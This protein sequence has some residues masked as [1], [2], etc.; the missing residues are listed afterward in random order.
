MLSDHYLVHSSDLYNAWH[1]VKPSLI[2][3][4]TQY[5]FVH[6]VLNEFILRGDTEILAPDLKTVI[7]R[8]NEISDGE[9]GF[10]K[11]FTVSMPQLDCAH[12][13]QIESWER[14]KF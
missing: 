13:M 10:C 4:Q 6:D 9:S 3:I 7:N 14:M 12:H 11:Q 8:L 1:L 5:N 2:Y